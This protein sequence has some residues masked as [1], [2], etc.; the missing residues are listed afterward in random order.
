M[1]SEDSPP[2]TA[3]KAF[4]AGSRNG[5]YQLERVD[6]YS[7]AGDLVRY[8]RDGSI[9]TYLSGSSPTTSAH[10]FDLSS[11]DLHRNAR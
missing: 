7:V 2:G 9:T 11:G 3:S 5:P 1:S 6:V 10:G 8:W 4:H